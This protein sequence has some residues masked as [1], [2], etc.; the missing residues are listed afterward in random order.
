VISPKELRSITFTKTPMG[1]FKAAEVSDFLDK[2]F[3]EYERIYNENNKLVQSLQVLAEKVE[4]YRGEEDRIKSALI[5]AQKMS[6]TILREA[7]HKCELNIR[8]AEI[9]AEKILEE[10][11]LKSDRI[12]K[13]AEQNIKNE[14]NALLTLQKEVS[15]FKDR[16]LTIYKEHITL[17]TALPSDD[18]EEFE[19][20]EASDV[21][22]QDIPEGSENNG[23]QIQDTLPETPEPSEKTPDF[24]PK[25]E[26]PS[27]LSQVAELAKTPEPPAPLENTAI[28]LSSID[29][30]LEDPSTVKSPFDN[31]QFGE[32]FSIETNEKGK[33]LFN[34]KK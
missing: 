30:L 20:A 22:K 6:D 23:A 28:D 3:D 27:T 33:G 16:L 11:A 18:E 2:T 5:S 32:D 25:E 31:L 14:E 29:D 9:R 7:K 10:A 21:Q 19:E 34:R 8:D 4:E 1:G 15:S 12:I 24:A 13:T 26:T 17:I